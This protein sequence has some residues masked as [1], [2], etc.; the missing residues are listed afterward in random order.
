M[1][2]AGFIF[3]KDYESGGIEYTLRAPTVGSSRSGT[4]GSENERGAPLRNEWDTILDKNSDYIKNWK[5][6][7]SWGQDTSDLHAEYS[8]ADYRAFRGFTTAR[9]WNGY[10]KG[11]NRI[12]YRPV[13]EIKNADTLGADGLKS[14]TLNLNGCTLNG[15]KF[16]A[17][18]KEGITAPNADEDF[19]GW[20]DGTNTYAPGESVPSSVTS[21][22]AKWEKHIHCLC[23]GNAYDGH[24]THESIEWQSWSATDSLPTAAGN[25]CLA[26]NV[27]LPSGIINLPDGVNICLN[28]KSVIG[29]DSSNTAVMV[30]GTITITDCGAEGSIGDMILTGDKSKLTMYG[31]KI[32]K[33]T[34]LRV[35]NQSVFTMTG[36]AQNDG[37]LRICFD[38]DFTMDGNAKNNNEIKL[39][40]TSDDG[41]IIFGGHAKGGTVTLEVPLEGAKI[42]LLGNATV[43][44]L[45][46]GG[47]VID[48]T[49]EDDAQIGNVTELIFQTISLS[50]NAK[51]GN[52]DSAFTIAEQNFLLG[53]NVQVIGKITYAVVRKNCVLTLQD[54]ARITGELIVNKSDGRSARVIMKDDSIMN[55]NLLCTDDGVSYEMQGNAKI[56]GDIDVANNRFSG[57]VTCTG[58]IKNGI[59]DVDGEVVNNGKI[60]GGIFYG[61]VSGTGTIEDSAKVDVIFNTDGGSAIDTQKIL[62][63]QKATAPADCKKAGYTFNCWNKGGEAYDFTTPVLEEFTLTAQWTA[64]NYTVSFETDGGS[65]ISDKTLGW[66]DKVL[67]SIAN[68]TRSGYEFKGWKC[69]DTH[70]TADIA[71]ADLAENDTVTNITLTAQWQDIEEPTGEIEIGENK[72]NSFLNTITFG[73]FF[74]DTQTVTITATDN[75]GE[76]VK[77]EYLLSGEELTKAEL[78]NK[79]FTEYTDSFNITPDNE[80]IIYVK[81]TDKAGNTSYICSNGIVLDGT[82]PVIVGIENGKIYCESQ[83]VRIDEKYIDSVTINETAVTSNENNQFVLAPADGEQKIVVTDKAGN[84]A[85]MTVTVNDGHTPLADDNDCTTPVYCKFCNAEVISAKN[86]DFTGEWHNDDNEHWHECLN[87][88]C[89]VTDTKTA[90][91]GTDDGDCTTAVVCECGFIITA[92]K[93]EHSYGD[94]QSNG[95]GTHTRYCTVNGCD[96]FETGDCTGGKATCKDKAKCEICHEPYGEFDENNHDGGTEIR[97]ELKAT[98]TK[99]GYTGDTYCLGCEKLLAKGSV[100]EATG[101]TGGKATCKDKAKCEVC[102]EAYGELDPKNHGDLKH[103]EAKAATKDA[104]GNTEY[105]YCKDCGK[106]YSDLTATKEIAKTDTVTKK[107][108][109]SDKTPQTGDGSESLALWFILLLIGN[110]ATVC[111][112]VVRKNKKRFVR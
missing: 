18:A 110:G 97:D 84:S 1:D 34:T 65:A 31:G 76:A 67:E 98:C 96:G 32:A 22:T 86:H 57:K 41:N 35:E 109:D 85:E 25:Y 93:D 74:N 54:N 47:Y 48:L 107:L 15:E 42:C 52:E 16:T 79:S 100:I 2:E 88:G 24:D 99:D 71:Y 103:T 46:G 44:S 101:H 104:E 9:L 50:K 27:T 70:V 62:R 28:G 45:S 80:Y 51:L 77:I 59:F 64:N 75:S 39:E 72:W 66:E 13:L 5:K 83:T 10:P 108:P 7:D 102:G 91:S 106:Y 58:E 11:D 29:T 69:G 53:D 12:S 43:D 73:L 78:A 105:W 4:F 95:D 61:T 63:G 19:V 68:P 94:W 23:G 14:V 38:A 21:L 30:D 33:D 49:M 90:H 111:A 40:Q 8:K 20:S 112:T 87:D 3:G 56:D 36:N 82:S 26:N 89:T 55:G 92:A 60:T 17:P 81:L 37:T 6:T